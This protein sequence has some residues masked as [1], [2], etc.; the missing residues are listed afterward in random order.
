MRQKVSLAQILRESV[1]LVCEA[2]SLNCGSPHA[3]YACA[4]RKKSKITGEVASIF[5]WKIHGSLSIS[6]L[7][8]DRAASF[9]AANVQPYTLKVMDS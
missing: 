1:K 6:L 7:I 4:L 8:I 2:L 9:D 3:H 5:G